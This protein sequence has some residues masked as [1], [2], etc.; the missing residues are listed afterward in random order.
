MGANYR[1]DRHEDGTLLLTVENVHGDILTFDGIRGNMME[2]S[3]MESYFDE[4]EEGHDPLTLPE[5]LKYAEE[6]LTD[7][8]I[9]VEATHR[10]VDELAP[11]FAEYA[12]SEEEATREEINKLRYYI[13]ARRGVIARRENTVKEYRAK[14]QVYQAR[15]M[16]ERAEIDRIKDGI[17][18]LEKRITALENVLKE[19]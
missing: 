11:W 5:S 4:I 19:A 12:I 17:R 9:S 14:Q 7:W 13:E 6:F 15:I 18:D 2:S 1:I 10:I 16:E 8:E 3:D